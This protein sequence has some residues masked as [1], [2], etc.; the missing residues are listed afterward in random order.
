[1]N[2]DNTNDTAPNY[3]DLW[4]LGTDAANMLDTCASAIDGLVYACDDEAGGY[5]MSEPVYRTM[6]GLQTMMRTHARTIRGVT[7]RV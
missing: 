7:E 3:S 4:T 1:M 5:S 2:H 6:R